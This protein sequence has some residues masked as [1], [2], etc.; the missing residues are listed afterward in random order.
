MGASSSNITGWL[1]NTFRDSLHNHL[2]SPSV[3]LTCFPGRAARTAS[4][5]ST[6]P[7]MS[8]SEDMPWWRRDNNSTL[9]WL[10]VKPRNI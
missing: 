1:I 2:I 10:W 3:R 5:L 9:S 4:S 7:S 8:G 6:I